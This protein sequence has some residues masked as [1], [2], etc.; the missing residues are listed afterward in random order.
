MSDGFTITKEHRKTAYRTLRKLLWS[1]LA[2]LAVFGIFGIVNPF[3]FWAD[4]LQSFLVIGGW[5]I[6]Y[7]VLEAVRRA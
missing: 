1:L 3:T 6:G 7:H 4:P 5:V 2:V